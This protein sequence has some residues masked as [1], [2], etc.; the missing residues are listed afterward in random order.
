MAS[1]FSVIRYHL[2]RVAIA[3]RIH[4]IRKF[5]SE[6]ISLLTV[7]SITDKLII[8]KLITDN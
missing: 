5:Q 1:Q 8:D 2:C 6:A 4:L 7:Q 3:A